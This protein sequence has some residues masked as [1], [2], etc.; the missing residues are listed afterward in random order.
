MSDWLADEIRKDEDERKRKEIEY[1]PLSEALRVFWFELNRVVESLIESHRVGKLEYKPG[2]GQFE[3]CDID[4]GRRRVVVENPGVL[5]HQKPYLVVRRSTL[6]ERGEKW[7][8]EERLEPH[9]D[10]P[11]RWQIRF[12]SKDEQEPRTPEQV[13]NYLLRWLLSASQATFG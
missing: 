2:S 3:V 11:N 6:E 5:P 13:A 8:L 12:T 9:L 4:I 7:E 10:S 1:R